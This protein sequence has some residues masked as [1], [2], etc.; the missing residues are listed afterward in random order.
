MRARTSLSI[1][2]LVVITGLAVPARAGNL[3]RIDAS[4]GRTVGVL[5]A[6]DG[7]GISASLSALWPVEEGPLSAG[8]ML[9]AD[10]LGSELGRLRDP[11]DGTDLGAV[12]LSHRQAYGGAW[13][14]DLD[15]PSW[16]G[17]RSFGSGTWGYYRIQDDRRGA[18]LGALSSAGF[19]LGTGARRVLAGTQSVGLA[20]RYHR[21]F[22]DRAGRY[23]SVAADW[24][25]LW[26]Q[27][28]Q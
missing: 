16:R 13:R 11:N 18:S 9:F 27:K 14:V 7:G 26:G 12:A 3:P 17:W 2:G 22:N 5:G 10:D 8:A 20:V 24:F 19:S 15:G 1:L 28:P 23:V 4:L 6:I 25:W 21:L